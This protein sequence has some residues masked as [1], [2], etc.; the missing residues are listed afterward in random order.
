M[1]GGP[2]GLPVLRVRPNAKEPYR[3]GV[4]E[5]TTDAATIKKWFS[6]E[7]GLNYGIAMGDGL[8]ALDCDAKHDSFGVEYL[9]LMA[10]TSLEFTSANDGAHIILRTDFEASQAKLAGATSIDVRAKGGYIVGPGSVVNGK[11]YRVCGDA[12]IADCPPHIAARLSRR[13][14]KAVDNSTPVAELDTPGAI[15]WAEEFVQRAA[16]AELGN[17]N[18]ELFRLACVLKDKGLS[19]E[20]THALLVDEWCPRC[21]PPYE[22]GAEIEASVASAY[23]N[24]QRPPGIEAIEL[25]FEDISADPD[26]IAWQAKFAANENPAPAPASGPLLEFV[27]DI[28]LDD[29]IGRQSNALVKG[30]LHPGDAAVLYGESTAGKSFIGLDMAWHIAMGKD[31]HG[32]K[33]NKAPVLYVA[34]EG[35]DGF[36][37]RMLAALQVHGE[38]GAYLARLNLHVSLAQ[39]KAGDQGMAK[40]IEA[41]ELLAAKAGQPVG[42]IIVDTYARA[43]AGDDENATDAVMH[44]VDKRVGAITRATGAA[45]LT[46]AHTNRAGDLRGSLHMRN[47]MDVVLRVTREERMVPNADGEHGPPFRCVMGDKVKDG[48]E[49]TLFDFTLSE[50]HL[51]EDEAGEAVTSCVVEATPPKPKSDKPP[52]ELPAARLFRAVHKELASKGDDPTLAD[53]KDG[54]TT[55]Y[56]TRGERDPAKVATATRNAWHRLVHSLPKGFETY[57]RGGVE[58][59]RK[60]GQTSPCDEFEPI[61]DIVTSVTSVTRNECNNVTLDRVTVTNVTLSFRSVTYVTPVSAARSLRGK[62]VSPWSKRS[63]LGQDGGGLMPLEPGVHPSPLALCLLL[64]LEPARIGRGHAGALVPGTLIAQRGS[65]DEMPKQGAGPHGRTP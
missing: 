36:R 21:D 56:T 55:R 4:N 11:R 48:Q 27:S 33:V 41:A 50:V 46:V 53:L 31:W 24:G 35:V 32:R 18:A 28:C 38:P 61:G 17:R 62:W 54:F 29:I 44:F 9:E 52:K 2:R 14:E 57:D 1:G 7:P 45:V 16:G 60:A 42:A 40:I 10:P 13:G 26:L 58:R 43:T 25:E 49:G 20:T 30:L 65:A 22:D 63:T 39:A 59:V 37:K 51:G 34:L 15:A 8:V 6:A 64:Q 12:P 19:L 47:A 23:V 3:G 5:A